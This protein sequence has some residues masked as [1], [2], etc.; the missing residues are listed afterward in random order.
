MA[1]FFFL[2]NC[3]TT[4][5]I[6]S[7][8]LQEPTHGK[9]S[10]IPTTAQKKQPSQVKYF[11][12]VYLPGLTECSTTIIVPWKLSYNG[13]EPAHKN[14]SIIPFLRV[15]RRK[16]PSQVKQ[17]NSV[18]LPGLTECS[19]ACLVLVRETKLPAHPGCDGCEWN[20][21]SEA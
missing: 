6:L 21:F 14:A 3:A 18:F 13:Q 9:A 4:V 15:R 16:Q 2:E 10:T 17:F 20:P 11:S 7:L 12:L 5:I 8:R 19:T 1:R